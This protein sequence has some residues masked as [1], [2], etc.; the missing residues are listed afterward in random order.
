MHSSVDE[1]IQK[2]NADTTLGWK[3]S[4]KKYAQ[5]SPCTT[6]DSD[7]SQAQRMPAIDRSSTKSANP[8][9]EGHVAAATAAAVAASVDDG[10]ALA[11]PLNWSLRKFSGPFTHPTP[12]T[13]PRGTKLTM[14]HD[15]ADRPHY[16]K[17]DP[18]VMQRMRQMAAASGGQHSKVR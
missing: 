16:Y 4:H 15:P 12:I 11:L 8:A 3:A 13:L 10:S 7:S 1:A 17:D 14:F 5:S 2:I 18:A 9:I 6:S